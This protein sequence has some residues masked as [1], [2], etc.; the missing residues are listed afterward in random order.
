LGVDGFVND[1]K[2][3]DGKLVDGILGVDAERFPPSD[4]FTPSSLLVFVDGE[5]GEIERFCFPDCGFVAVVLPKLL[6]PNGGKGIFDKL[7]GKVEA[8]GKVVPGF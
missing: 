4:G 7:G 3:V 1:G 6:L 2:L 5:F 8:E